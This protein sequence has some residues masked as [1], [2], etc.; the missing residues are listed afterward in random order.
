MEMAMT[1]TVEPFNSSQRRPGALFQFFARFL[2]IDG[3]RADLSLPPQ[4]A[5]D[6]PDHHRPNQNCCPIVH[7]LIKFQT[8]A[9]RHFNLG[10]ASQLKLAEREGFEPPLGFHPKR[11]S[12]PP[13]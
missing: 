1:S 2:K 11:F 5:K 8:T 10:F 4:E 7:K 3:Q 6:R 9:S 12:R 13:R